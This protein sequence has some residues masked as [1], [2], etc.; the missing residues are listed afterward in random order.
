[1]HLWTCPPEWSGETVFIVAGGPSV[2]RQDTDRLK[3]R[4]VIVINSSYQRVPFADILFFGD[5]RWYYDHKPMLAKFAGRK[6]AVSVSVTE[7]PY[8]LMRK[9]APPPG[10]SDNRST[11]VMR[12]TSLHG[13]I[14]LAVHLG[15]KRIVVLGADMQAAKDGRTHHHKPHGYTVKPG[16]W[17][18]QIDELRL[19]NKPAGRLGVQIINASPSSRI[20]FW[21]QHSFEE[22]LSWP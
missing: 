11:V 13:A 17:D 1:M 4:K 12:R 18:E 2:A 7:K 19:I 21:P 20:G 5:S 22:C 15:S 8:L 6:V 16:C 3:G 14:N 10:L 9:I